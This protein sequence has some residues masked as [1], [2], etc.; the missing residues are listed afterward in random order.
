MW[1]ILKLNYKREAITLALNNLNEQGIKPE[2]INTTT[3]EDEIWITY[4]K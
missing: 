3:V 2:H 1:Y 4:Y